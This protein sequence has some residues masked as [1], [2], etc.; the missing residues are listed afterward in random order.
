M[1]DMETDV[2]NPKLKARLLE[3]ERLMEHISLELT[4]PFQIDMKNNAIQHA[5][6]L[7]NNTESIL[8]TGVLPSE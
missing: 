7:V 2:L 5:A 4:A 3:I 6:T 1:K 8:A